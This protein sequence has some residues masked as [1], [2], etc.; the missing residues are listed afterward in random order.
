MISFWID[1]GTNFIGGTES[2]QSEGAW[3]VPLTLQ[4]VPALVLIVGMVFMPFSPRWLVHHDREEEARKVLGLLRN[5]SP[6]SEIIELEL[7][8]IKAQSLFEQRTIAEHYPK[9]AD[10]TVWNTLKLQFVAIGSLFKSKPMLRRVV[11]GT[12]TMFFQQWTGINAV[13][14]YAPSIFADLGLSS[15]TT[16]LL[17]TGVVGIVMLAA[18][19]PAILY[20]DKIGRR[21]IL[22]GGAIGMA[23]CHF[24]IAIIFAKNQYQWASQTAA[25]WAAIVFV[26]VFVMFFGASWGPAAWILISEVWPISARPYGMAL[27]ASSNWLNNFIVG[28][29]TPDM[30]QSMTYG[31]CFLFV[32]P[33]RS[34]SEALS[35]CFGCFR[36][37]PSKRDCL[38]IQFTAVTAS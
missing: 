17:A 30:L 29:V 9:L 21:P 32:Q 16:S 31:E 11:V 4:L 27:S 5:E 20:I 34:I 28:Q 19:V 26:W 23:A 25:G 1:Y 24:I 37:T 10:Q 6:D 14:Y 3:L 36:S 7:L 15:N 38:V 18:T 35:G 8:E 12:V 2:T 13:L 22:A 33:F